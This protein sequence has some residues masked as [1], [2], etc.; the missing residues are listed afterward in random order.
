MDKPQVTS[1]MDKPQVTS[2]MDMPG[3][4]KHVVTGWDKFKNFWAGVHN[5]TTAK[6]GLPEAHLISGDDEDVYNTKTKN[7]DYDWK[8]ANEN[9]K[10]KLGRE[11]AGLDIGKLI[12]TGTKVVGML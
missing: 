10:K 1:S 7:W 12:Q 3:R 11:R 8:K 5:N 6:L 2:S 9:A 4:R